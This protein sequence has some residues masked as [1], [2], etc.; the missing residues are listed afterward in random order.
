MAFTTA[1][2]DTIDRAIAS[3]ELSVRFSDGREVTYRAISELLTARDAIK[4]A[5][6]PS[7]IRCTYAKF[8]KD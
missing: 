4:Q 1:D 2:I 6:N 8:T 7:A 3:G 5:L